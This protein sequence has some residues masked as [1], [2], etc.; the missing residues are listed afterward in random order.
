MNS[1]AKIVL[2]EDE[3]IIA[4]SIAQELQKS[5]YDVVAIASSAEQALAAIAR[6]IP[7]LVLMDIRIKGS[8]DG[9][10]AAQQIPQNLGIPVI[11]MSAH[12]DKKTLDRAKAA[13]ASG[14]L[15]KPIPRGALVAA[16]EAALSNRGAKSAAPK[17]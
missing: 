3:L 6:S 10:Q 8:V 1:R 16:I 4:A 11:F 5:G 13:G 12:S 7:E 17:Q 15:V 14:Y 2:V 9:I